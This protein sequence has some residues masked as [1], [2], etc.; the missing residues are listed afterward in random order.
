MLQNTDE[1]VFHLLRVTVNSV[2]AL[3]LQYY[4]TYFVTLADIFFL[5]K[6]K[7]VCSFG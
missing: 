6:S 4:E 2:N 5:N 1:K 7:L 3:I